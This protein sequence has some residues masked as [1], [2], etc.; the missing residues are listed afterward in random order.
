MATKTEDRAATIWL[1]NSAPIAPYDGAEAVTHRDG[2]APY[3]EG[4]ITESAHEQIAV[5]TAEGERDRVVAAVRDF[6]QVGPTITTVARPASTVEN[7]LYATKAVF[8]L[9]SAAAPMWVASDNYEVAQAISEEF[10]CPILPA[11]LGALAAEQREQ[12]DRIADQIEG[13]TA[14]LLNGGRDALFDQHFTTGAQPAAFNYIGLTANST[15]PAA[16]DTTLTGQ[17]TTAGGGL[18][19]AQ[20]TYA[21]TAGTA[22]A[23]L[24]KTFTA[25]GSDTLPVTIAKVGVRNASGTGGTLGTETLLSSTATLS[26]SGDALT[27]TMTFTNNPS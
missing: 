23:T 5:R 17:I 16:T 21:H 4:N 22:T 25:N 2:E 20:A 27:V 1:G 7:H 9:H 18:V 19:A 13:P 15:A 11:D 14:L 3:Y 6:R 26:A 24:S 12:W 10:G 8:G